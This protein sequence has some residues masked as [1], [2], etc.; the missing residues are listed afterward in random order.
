M[1]NKANQARVRKIASGFNIQFDAYDVLDKA[2]HLD[3][4]T[5]S[6]VLNEMRAEGEIERV[7]KHSDWIPM[8]RRTA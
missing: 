4:D 5:I 2:P 7:E 8:Y 6:G 3:A 1:A